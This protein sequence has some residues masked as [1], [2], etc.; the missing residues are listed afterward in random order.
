[1]KSCS[2]TIRLTA[3]KPA[4]YYGVSSANSCFD[5]NGI[6][7]AV[8]AAGSAFYA[9]ILMSQEG[10]FFIYAYHGMGTNISTCSAPYT[11]LCIDIYLDN[12]LN[13]LHAAFVPPQLLEYFYYHK[14]QS[15]QCSDPCNRHSQQSLFFHAG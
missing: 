11:F 3:S 12:I 9:S 14:D 5:I 2:T 6:Y 1:M 10:R 13:I 7:G 8:F 15:S 4:F